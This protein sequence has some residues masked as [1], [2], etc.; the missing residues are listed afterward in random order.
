[1]AMTF[2]VIEFIYE[3]TVASFADRIK[4]LLV[5]AGKS[6]NRVFGGIFIA[7]GVLLPLR[8]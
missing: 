4:P 7:I 8:G 1:M 2:L 6:F 5:R 3:F